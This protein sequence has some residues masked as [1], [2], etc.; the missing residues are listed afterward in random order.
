[1]RALRIRL[2]AL[3]ALGALATPVKSGE[4]LVPASKVVI[5]PGDI[6]GDDALQDVPLSGAGIGGPFALSRVDVVGKAARRTL[7]PGRAIPLA[8]I[9]NPRLF[10]NGAEVTIIYI[11]GGLTI[12][13]MGAALQDGA[14]GETVKVRNTDSGVTIQGRV[15]SDG[16]V[17]VGEG[18]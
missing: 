14:L 17:L 2:A 11:D 7:L 4:L 3:I 1:M 5:Y 13:T 6:I 15:R 12:T 9:D 10:R 8:A 18:G 16:S